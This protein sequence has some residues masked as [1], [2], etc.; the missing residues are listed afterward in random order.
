MMEICEN[1]IKTVIGET[2][3]IISLD[4]GSCVYKTTTELSDIDRLIIVEDGLFNEDDYVNK[5]YQTINT[6]NT[7]NID[8]Q[9]IQ[10]STWKQM[11]ENYDIRA[12]ES[13][14]LPN[15][16]I[17]CGSSINIPFKDIFVLDLEKLR[18]CISAICSNAWVKSKKK[19]QYNTPDNDYKA[20]KSLFHV[21]RLFMFGIQIAK[22]GK[23]INYQEANYLWEEIYNTKTNDWTYYKEKYQPLRNKLHSQFV[24]LTDK[25]YWKKNED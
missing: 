12:I 17:Y 1:N 6:K 15:E 23:I 18:R 21:F 9:Y 14:W 7:P 24:E 25:K 16:N 4:Y 8:E 11:I 10:I 20:K 13:L 2:K 19:F 5:T 22:Y 3:P